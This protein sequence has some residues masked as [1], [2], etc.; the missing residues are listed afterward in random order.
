MTDPSKQKPKTGSRYLARV[1]LAL[2]L[3]LSLVPSP[4]RAADNPQVIE[5]MATLKGETAKLGAPK[6]EGDNFI[7]GTTKMNDNFQIVDEVKT[8]HSATATVFAKKGT[9]Y[10]RIT[11]NVMKDGKRAVGSVLDSS[12]PAYASIN[13][14]KAFYGLVDILGKMYDTGYEPI[15]TEAGEVIGI[16]YVGFLME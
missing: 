15:K 14:G 9:N 2:V 8:K 13:Q 6:L 3:S 7:F 16:W 10:V 1:F 4:V 5:A 12:G 11:T